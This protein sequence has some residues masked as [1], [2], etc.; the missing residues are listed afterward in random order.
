MRSKFS[1]SEY[2]YCTLLMGRWVFERE[3]TSHPYMLRLRI[4]NEVANTSYAYCRVSLR[5]F[6]LFLLLFPLLFLLFLVLLP[7]SPSSSFFFK[8]Y[9]FGHLELNLCRCS[10]SFG[11]CWQIMMSSQFAFDWL[12]K[13]MNYRS[14]GTFRGHSWRWYRLMRLLEQAFSSWLLMILMD[15]AAFA[16]DW[17]QVGGTFRS[18]FGYI[19][20][21]WL[22][23][24]V[25]L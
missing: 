22:Q 25:V 4:F 16:M 12:T 7:S 10:H 15:T 14:S 13:T 19:H 5:V 17:N 1:Y 18:S 9:I 24:R 8:S 21:A 11:F 2:T 20:L 3:L 23:F 6:F